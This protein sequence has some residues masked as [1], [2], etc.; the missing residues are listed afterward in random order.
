M[1]NITSPT[2]VVTWVIATTLCL[3]FL[4]YHAPAHLSQKTSIHPL[5]YLHLIGAYS[6]Y[7]VC[8]HN[9]LLTPSTFKGAARP[10]HILIGRVGLVLGVMGFVT[11]VVVVWII[12]DYTENWGFSIGITFGGT[13]QMI[14]QYKGYKAIRAFQDIKRQ[15][16]SGEYKN[17]EKELNLLRKE[18][19]KQLSTHVECMIRLFVL[20]CGIPALIR[21][22]D[23]YEIHLLILFGIAN[24][25]SFA[26]TNSFL[27]GIKA[28]RALVE[29][30]TKKPK[31]NSQDKGDKQN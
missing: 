9:T 6:V 14:A 5:L 22:S 12:Y 31:S 2:F 3:W 1:T 29:G 30:N 27:D 19:D 7:L 26:M 13:Q 18:Q 21:I 23:A 10:F 15:I 24:I 4:F 16:S 8:V 11:G 28:S 17:N 20:A 25:L